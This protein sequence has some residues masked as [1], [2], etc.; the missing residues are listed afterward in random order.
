M[1]VKFETWSA[2]G[3]GVSKGPERKLVGADVES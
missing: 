1:D 3:P 2:D